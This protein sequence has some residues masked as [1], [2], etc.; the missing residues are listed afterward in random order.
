MLICPIKALSFCFF[1]FFPAFH[2]EVKRRAKA[3]KKL[4]FIEKDNLEERAEKKLIVFIMI[5]D[6]AVIYTTPGVMN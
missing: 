1:S 2:S 6:I 4:F 3:K 5:I